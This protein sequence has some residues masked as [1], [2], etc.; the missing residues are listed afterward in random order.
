MQDL[1]ELLNS[2][3]VG[4]DGKYITEEQFNAL[5]IDKKLERERDEA[6]AQLAVWKHEAEKLSDELKKADDALEANIT[7]FLDLR[8]ER[9]RLAEAL[10]QLMTYAPNSYC[11]DQHERHVWKDAE[12]ALRTTRNMK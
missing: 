5:S 1:F 7:T 9:D 4:C 11:E 12:E 10:E 6:R 2:Y 8:E 3:S